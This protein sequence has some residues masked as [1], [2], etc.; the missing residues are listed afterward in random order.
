LPLANANPPNRLCARALYVVGVC[1]HGGIVTRS[2][3]IASIKEEKAEN[4]TRLEFCAAGLTRR[5]VGRSFLN[6]RVAA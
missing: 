5:T 2:A 6:R 1:R 4:Y 3:N